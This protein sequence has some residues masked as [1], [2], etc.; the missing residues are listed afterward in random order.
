MRE[1]DDI[2]GENEEGADGNSN[3]KTKTF[4]GG[5]SIVRKTKAL[6][7]LKELEQ[8]EAMK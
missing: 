3:S 8:Q 6:K 5:S 2:E 7:A 1:G 4:I